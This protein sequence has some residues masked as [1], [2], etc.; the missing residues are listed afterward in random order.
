MDEFRWD[1]ALVWTVSNAYVTGPA[2][3][4]SR[5]DR[6]TRLRHDPAGRRHD[7][8]GEKIEP[9]SLKKNLNGVEFWRRRYKSL[10][11]AENLVDENLSKNGEKLSNRRKTKH[12]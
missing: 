10:F 9:V 3:R 8:V 1:I 2:W 6:E 4:C 12:P 11:T 7:G 5:E